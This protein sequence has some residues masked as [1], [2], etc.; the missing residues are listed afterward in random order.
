MA[1][2]EA[3]ISRIIQESEEQE[4]EIKAKAEQEAAKI[5]EKAN[6]DA[7]EAANAIE[8][9]AKARAEE[10]R[11]RAFTMAELE[12][13]KEILNE[14][15]IQISNAF[16]GAVQKIADMD[17]SEYQSIILRMLVESVETGD[18][19]VSISPKDKNRLT[20]EFIHAANEELKK[21]GKNGALKL[22]VD[23]EDFGGGFVLKSAQYTINSSFKSIIKMQRDELEPEV[24]GIL[25]Q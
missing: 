7:K 22:A 25:F 23:T 4:N 1:G 2:A 13:R 11:R 5:L 9:K 24:A 12:S 21:M 8:E 16:A 15:Q 6:V 20:D 14:K 18:E 17:T 3:L 19:T 10:N